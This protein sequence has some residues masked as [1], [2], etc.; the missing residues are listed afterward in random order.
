MNINYRSIFGEPKPYIEFT[1]CI[2]CLN[3]EDGSNPS[4]KLTNE[5]IV[6]EF[7]GGKIVVNN[8]C[9]E[10]NSTLGHTLEGPLSNNIYFKLYAYF[11]EIKGKKIS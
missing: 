7:I 3:P 9:K 6:P 5:H 11:N 8:V 1:K 4:R 2:I 10:C